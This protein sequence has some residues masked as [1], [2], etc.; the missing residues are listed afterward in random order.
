MAKRADPAEPMPLDERLCLALYRASRA[1][2]ARYRPPLS[3]LGLTYPQYLVMVLLWEEGPSS[4]GQIGARLD[5]ESSTLSP[6]L[7]RLQ[8][9]GLI[10]RA[11]DERDERSVVVSLTEQGAGLEARAAGVAVEMCVAVGMAPQ[12]QAALV[13]ELGE[14][15]LQLQASTPFKFPFDRPPD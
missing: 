8:V 4:V 10:V 9:M 15:A 7:K 13:A 14:L 6:L 2:T 5:L 12:K 3:A 1:M 11:R